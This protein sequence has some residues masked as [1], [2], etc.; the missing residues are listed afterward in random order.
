MLLLLGWNISILF[1]ITFLITAACHPKCL[2]C[3]A[4]DTCIECTY[5]N[6]STPDCDCTDSNFYMDSNF[7]CLS[8]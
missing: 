6:T 5:E 1:L 3:L 4:Y 2:T 7:K 8:N